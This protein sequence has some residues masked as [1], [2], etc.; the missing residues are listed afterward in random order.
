MTS[1]PPRD[2]PVFRSGGHGDGKVAALV[3]WALYIL[4]IPSANILVLVGLVV[5]YAGRSSATGLALEHLNAQ[6]RLF[7]SVFWWTIACWI[8]IA[9][10]VVASVI[11]I[12]IP[13]LIVF[14]L[15]WFLI[16]VWFTV[17]SI[18]G[19]INLLGDRAP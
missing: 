1:T 10:S 15:L 19:L 5:A 2:E 6:I 14:A 3:A 13:F 4:S 11:L 9:V 17:K 18:F 7:W 12:G 16:S 8:A